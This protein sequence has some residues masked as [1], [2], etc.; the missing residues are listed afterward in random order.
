LSYGNSIGRSLLIA[1]F[2]V[3]L[4]CAPRCFWERNAVASRIGLDEGLRQ[5]AV[6]T[7]VPL[8]QPQKTAAGGRE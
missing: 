8:R 4:P 7:Q 2:G 6:W 5:L 3:A 1:G